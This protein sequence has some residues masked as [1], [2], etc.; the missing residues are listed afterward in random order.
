MSYILYSILVTVLLNFMQL[1]FV[2]AQQAPSS[3]NFKRKDKFS[4]S[5]VSR[6]VG[7]EE[8]KR[9]NPFYGAK[10]PFNKLY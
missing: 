4:E 7:R 6:V 8:G 3:L 9:K 2:H 1:H 10:G 5:H